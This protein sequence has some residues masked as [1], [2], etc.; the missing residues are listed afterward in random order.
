MLSNTVHAV[1]YLL[2]FALLLAGCGVQNLAGVDLATVAITPTP[3]SAPTTTPD[4][5][6]IQLPNMTT[7]EFVDTSVSFSYPAGWQRDE[8]GQTLTVSDPEADLVVTVFIRPTGDIEVDGD[9]ENIA[10]QVMQFFLQQAAEFGAVPPE[11]APGPDEALPFRWG[12][13]D[14]AIF[15]WHGEDRTGA[16]VLVLNDDRDRLIFFGTETAPERWEAFEPTWLA[17]L[18]TVVLNGEALPAADVITA[19]REAMAG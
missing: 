3:T 1:R 7:K 18:G 11:S 15:P 10:A 9:A 17:V 8:G 6:A 4:P 12:E 16:N 5:S 2:P 19:Y 13:Q 14:A